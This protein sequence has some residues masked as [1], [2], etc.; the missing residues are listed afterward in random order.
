MFKTIRVMNDSREIVLHIG[1]L[2]I[3]YDKLHHNNIIQR[4]MKECP[5]HDIPMH[6]VSQHICQTEY[7]QIIR[8]CIR[9]TLGLSPAP[10]FD[11]LDR[12]IKIVRKNILHIIAGPIY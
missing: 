12:K 10:C 1:K 9:L 7:H 8:S 5:E 11:P 2:Y 6:L 3:I 4:Q